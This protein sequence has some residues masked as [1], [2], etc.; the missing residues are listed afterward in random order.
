MRARVLFV[1]CAVCC[2]CGDCLCDVCL[3]VVCL[4][5]ALL[6]SAVADV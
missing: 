4:L 2:V 5:C 3:Y 1:L 6:L